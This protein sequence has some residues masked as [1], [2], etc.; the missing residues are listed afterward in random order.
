[1]QENGQYIK[2]RERVMG[3][4]DKIKLLSKNDFQFIVSELKR[5][6]DQFI[7]QFALYLESEREKL[8]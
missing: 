4:Y 7:Q 6:E 5:N 3:F 8:N 1:M 2:D